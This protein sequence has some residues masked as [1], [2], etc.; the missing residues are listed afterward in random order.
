M[1]ATGPKISDAGI[2]YHLA[3]IMNPLI[4]WLQQ[5]LTPGRK[6]NGAKS[7]LE[8]LKVDLI[9]TEREIP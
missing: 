6:V 7:H 3:P 2:Q 4:D 1:V 9:L 5:R 8:M